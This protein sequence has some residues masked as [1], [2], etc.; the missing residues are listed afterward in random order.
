MV[1]YYLATPSYVQSRD[2]VGGDSLTA[3][4]WQLPAFLNWSA[5]WLELIATSQMSSM[6]G[7]STTSTTPCMF[8]YAW[9]IIGYDWLRRFKKDHQYQSLKSTNDCRP[10]EGGEGGKVHWASFDEVKVSGDKC[11]LITWCFANVH[12]QHTHAHARTHTHTQMSSKHKHTLLFANTSASRQKLPNHSFEGK[13][14]REHR[15]GQ[16][17][18]VC[19]CMW[20]RKG[21]EKIVHTLD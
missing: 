12:A 13:L 7:H 8:S 20:Q 15:S 9:H 21:S 5:V 10:E 3:H 19:D 17:Q 16:C 11:R 18:T 1:Q 14:E 2:T 4:H 6:Y